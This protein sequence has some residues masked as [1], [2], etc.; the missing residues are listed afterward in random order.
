MLNSDI[1][2][3]VWPEW[4]IISYIDS[5][6]YGAVYRAV[7]REH[8]VESFAAIKVIS[9]PSSDSEVASLR[10]EG[11]DLEGTRTY[12]QEIVNDFVSEIQLMESL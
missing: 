1:L 2:K 7:R 3:G 11:F 6:S 5:G 12:F 10:S 4:K 8:N 9:I